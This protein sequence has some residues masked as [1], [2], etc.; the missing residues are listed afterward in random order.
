MSLSGQ[1]RLVHPGLKSLKRGCAKSDPWIWRCC[2]AKATT[3]KQGTRS[4]PSAFL[5]FAFRLHDHKSF[6]QIHDASD[7]HKSILMPQVDVYSYG[8]CLFELITRR[9]PYEGSG[10]LILAFRDIAG[11][12]L[13][14]STVKAIAPM[15]AHF[16]HPLPGLEPV[17]IAVAVSRGKRP[18][19]AFIP[20]EGG[21]SGFHPVTAVTGAMSRERVLLIASPPAS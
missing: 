13:T 17:S 4:S 12:A 1:G 18:D 21:A 5:G 9:I 6:L 11:Q 16:G 7:C 10:P 14:S 8:I 3:K 19:V 20:E 2:L 15:S